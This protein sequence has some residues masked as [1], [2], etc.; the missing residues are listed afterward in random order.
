MT[1]IL[2]KLHDHG[3]VPATLEDLQ[4]AFDGIPLS[5]IAMMPP[6]GT[7]TEKNLYRWKTCELV[8]GVLIVKGYSWPKSLLLSD[9]VYRL[10][11]WN[12]E[13]RAGLVLPGAWHRMSE[14]VVRTPDIAFTRWE[15]LRGRSLR[16]I[17]IADFPPDLVVDFVTEQNTSGEV[18]RKREEYRTA[19]VRTIWTVEIQERGVWA[20][21]AVDNHRE[22]LF[23]GAGSSLRTETLPGFQLEISDWF[24]RLEE[25]GRRIGSKS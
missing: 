4:E 9:L 19:G 12:R 14:S 15:K 16:E 23:Y 13:D 8:D 22:C 6:P 2:S 1:G 11:T 5:R 10:S 24:E 18:R 17:E 21:E 25:F 7:A 3:D 20:S